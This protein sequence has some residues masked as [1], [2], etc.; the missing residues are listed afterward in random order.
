MPVLQEKTLG[1]KILWEVLWFWIAV[2]GAYDLYRCVL[3]QQTF[4]TFEINPLVRIIVNWSGGDISLFAGLKTL[5][6][7]VTL[8]SLI[9]LRKFKYVWF[10]L[11]SLAAVQLVVLISYCPWLGLFG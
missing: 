6:T 8:A 2:I 1:R 4:M 7:P 11:Y 9:R 10:I 3:D 5:G